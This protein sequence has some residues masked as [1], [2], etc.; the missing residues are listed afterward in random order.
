MLVI[1][2][3][4]FYYID[5][6][7]LHTISIGDCASKH[8]LKSLRSLKLEYLPALTKLDF[9]NAYFLSL[10]QLHLDSLPMLTS[11]LV[12]INAL[13][14]CTKIIF[15]KLPSFKRIVAFNQNLII[16]S[17]IESL[18]IECMLNP[19]VIIRYSSFTTFRIWIFCSVVFDS[20]RGYLF[21]WVQKVFE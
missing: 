11:L 17:K 1:L 3:F 14:L 4:V 13:T 6:N 18:I 21:L 10:R 20:S 15:R 16:F 7:S 8:S 5:C 19:S 12:G 2:S 9:S